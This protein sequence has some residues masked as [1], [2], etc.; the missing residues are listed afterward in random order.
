MGVY[1]SK[2]ALLLLRNNVKS[3]FHVKNVRF[4]SQA[5]K[6][7]N[8][9]LDLELEGIKAAGTWKNERVI[10]S[11]QDIEINVDGSQGKILNFCAN[12]YLGLSSHPDVVQA[13]IDALKTHG[14]GLSS[15]RFIC[16]TQDIHKKLENQI[17]E[18]HGRED[19]ILY[20]SCFDAN[21]GLFEQIL[22]PEDAVFSDALNHASII[23]GIR[24]CKAKKS[25][26]E[27]KNMQDLEAKLQDASDAKIK[28]I[29]TDGVF[30]MD[31]NV[32]PLPE[33]C[34]LAEKYGALTF[35][36]ECHAT[37]FF[38]PSGRGA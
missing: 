32:A 8:E 28:M 19:S 37:G 25:R 29:V 21:A 27:H 20:A 5:L 23:D 7:V 4:V 22:G 13:G 38:G 34:D 6:L 24:L 26:Y 31:G 10:T 9:K 33:I 30:S 18:F 15:V 2:M 17:A 11:K 12:N 36:D 3:C 14:A 1:S 35:I 16:G